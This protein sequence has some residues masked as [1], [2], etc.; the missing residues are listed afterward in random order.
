[1]KTAIIIPTKTEKLLTQ[2]LGSHLLFTRRQDTAFVIVANG[3]QEERAQVR[4]AVEEF[5]LRWTG[6]GE[7]KLIEPPVPPGPPMPWQFYGNLCNL[8]ADRAIEGDA[9][10][11]VF[12]NDDTVVRPDWLGLLEEDFANCEGVVDHEQKPVLPG[13]MGAR[14]TFVVGP[15]CVFDPSL[16]A[17]K[18]AEMLL[19]KNTARAAAAGGGVQATWE[20]AA[21]AFPRIITFFAACTAK[22]YRAVG[23][24]DDALPAHNYSDDI[25]SVR[26]LKA[27]YHNF[28]SRLF[29][30]HFGSQTTAALGATDEARM[31]FYAK[32]M[33]DGAAYFAKAYPDADKVLAAEFR[34][35]GIR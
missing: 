24:F 7:V 15:Q 28:V 35:A 8:G 9:E 30:E 20:P 34:W 17:H 18:T 32:D 2:H 33:A 13:L 6:K 27:G 29:I 31:A 21:F 19:R 12:A 4:E 10:L 1:M 3:T 23:G 14:S 25:L 26:M 22:A 11:L 16:L 5:R